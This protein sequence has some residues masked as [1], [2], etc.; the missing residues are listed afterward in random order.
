VVEVH[1]LSRE[2]LMA[3]DA[4]NGFEPSNDHLVPLNAPFPSRG[5]RRQVAL[6]VGRIRVPT[7]P[8][9]I[10]AFSAIALKF[11]P[12]PIAVTKFVEGK[13]LSA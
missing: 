5:E 4:W 6:F 10:S 12:S 2:V 9:R 7:P 11:L 8:F 1:H 13:A 3:V